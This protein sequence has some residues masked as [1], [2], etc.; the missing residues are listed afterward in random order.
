MGL[1]AGIKHALNSTLGT[2]YFRPLDEILNRELLSSSNLYKKIFSGAISAGDDV[3]ETV[4]IPVTLKMYC[5]GTIRL[6][7]GIST[8]RSDGDHKF[9]VDVLH[10]DN[11]SN[12]YSTSNV[13]ENSSTSPLSDYYMQIGTIKINKGDIL[14]FSITTNVKYRSQSVKSLYI[15]ADEVQ[16][17]LFEINNE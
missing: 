15:L 4:N 12:A 6:Y 9:N 8:N 3:G 11:T 2:S 14:S 5:N 17:S 10:R 16:S 7:I 13:Y 1:W